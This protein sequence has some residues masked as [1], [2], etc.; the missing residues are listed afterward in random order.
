[1]RT[2][3]DEHRRLDSLHHLEQSNLPIVPIIFLTNEVLLNLASDLIGKRL[4]DEAVLVYQPKSFRSFVLRKRRRGQSHGI[5]E[6]T[7]DAEAGGTG[8]VDDDSLVLDLAHVS[9]QPN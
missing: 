4:L 5:A 3:S 1:M 7:G 8:S 2:R 9:N 6:L